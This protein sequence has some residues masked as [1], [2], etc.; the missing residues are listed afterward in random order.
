MSPG[1]ARIV[2][3]ML[4]VL[5]IGLAL[6]PA[7]MSLMSLGDIFLN[8]RWGLRQDYDPW[9]L[10]GVGGRAAWWFL[11]LGFGVYLIRHARRIGRLVYLECGR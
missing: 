10:L 8:S 9:W 4:G 6:R 1:E 2:V 7:W 5:V 3:R 11:A